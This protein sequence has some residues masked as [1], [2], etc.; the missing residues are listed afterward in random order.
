MSAPDHRDGTP[1]SAAALDLAARLLI[2][3]P[4]LLGGVQH[5]VRPE[6]VAE[7]L[8]EGPLSF[9]ATAIASAETMVIATG[10]LLIAG[11]LGMA[12]GLLTRWA[13]IGS[14]A[15]LVAISVTALVG[16]GEEA[17]PLI[18]NLAIFGG[19]LMVAA[20][21]A[22]AWSIDARWRRGRFAYRTGGVVFLLLLLVSQAARGEADYPP[23]A[24]APLVFAPAAALGGG[25]L[26][27]LAAALLL[28]FDGR[29]AGISSILGGMVDEP[30]Q[31]GWCGAFA[32]GLLAGGLLLRVVDPALLAIVTDRSL[33]AT[34]LAGGLVGIGTQL[35]SG[36]TSGHGVCGIG[37][38]S[39]RSLAAVLT[40]MATGALTVFVVGQLLGAG[41]G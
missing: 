3:L 34:A 15:L 24:A 13:A 31:R 27:G 32:L 8:A 29:L 33:A 28:L 30:G 39:P 12:L 19:L 7:R 40:F 22:G 1:R 17:G 37:R 25:A 26:I 9:L 18:K 2:S 36:C 35:G 14:M 23:A 38:G 4:F 6:S 5:L 41:V 16:V 11:G 20:R 21:G 10:W